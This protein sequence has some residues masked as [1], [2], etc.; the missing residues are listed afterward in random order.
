MRVSETVRRVN[1]GILQQPDTAAILRPRTGLDPAAQRAP[2][3]GAGGWERLPVDRQCRYRTVAEDWLDD[4]R[5][6]P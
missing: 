2:F 4:A 5:A 1:S 6:G 3:P